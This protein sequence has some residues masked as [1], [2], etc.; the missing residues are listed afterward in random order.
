MSAHSR[1]TSGTA[2]AWTCGHS[3]RDLVLGLG[4]IPAFSRGVFEPGEAIL[5]DVSDHCR[6]ASRKAVDS[7]RALAGFCPALVFAIRVN[8]LLKAAGAASAERRRIAEAALVHATYR[9]AARAVLRETRPECLVLGNG[10]RPFEFALFAEARRRGFATV[11][12]PYAEI[13]PKPERFFSLCRGAFDL[14]LPFSD[15][16]AAE[17]CKLRENAA[18][19]V[20]GF[21]RGSVR[22]E[23]EGISSKPEGKA[24]TVLY[25]SGNNFEQEVS[26]ILR[27][28]LADSKVR[29]LRVRLHPRNS[30]A[31]MRELFSWVAPDQ[32]S[33]PLKTPLA[34]DI[35]SADV[36]ITVRSTVAL[37]AIVAGVPVIWL[38]PKEHLAE[39]EGHPI[40]KQR[41]ALVEASKP[42][43]LRAIVETLGDEKERKRIADEQLRRLKAAGYTQ[44]YFEAVKVALRRLVDE[45]RAG[46][47]PRTA[48]VAAAATKP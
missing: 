26:A 27:D 17:I 22:S 32:I 3:R 36:A 41:L 18:I 39:I 45:L 30:E 21:P 23:G 47:H 40:R 14:A 1:P 24:L 10:N 16:S 8:S 7:L 28:A 15:H 13:N 33:Y 37:D 29:C 6:S 25:I 5:C 34:D 38:S 19:A 4:K 12:L 44:R 20:V 48:A 35:G 9:R 43:E 31:E 11:L 2:E 42:D 46:K